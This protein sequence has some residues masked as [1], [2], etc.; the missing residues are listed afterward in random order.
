[1]RFFFQYNIPTEK[2]IK[3]YKQLETENERF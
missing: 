3:A 1:M 2:K